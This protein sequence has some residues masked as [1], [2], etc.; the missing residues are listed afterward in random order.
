MNSE[1]I[2]KLIKIEKLKYEIIKDI[3]PEKALSRLNKFE[4]Q[5]A[6]V[7]SDITLEVMREFSEE[8]EEEAKKEI[9]KVKVDFL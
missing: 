6:T 4:K 1:I 2:K 9:K 5:T 8:D 3:L 7:I